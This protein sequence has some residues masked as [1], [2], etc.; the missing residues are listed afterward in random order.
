M[1]NADVN[2]GGVSAQNEQNIIAHGL[3]NTKEAREARYKEI[4]SG[5]TVAYTN[6]APEVKTEEETLP[7]TTKTTTKRIGGEV[8]DP[9]KQKL[10]ETI[11]IQN[12]QINSLEEQINSLTTQL[13]SINALTDENM[14]LKKDIISLKKEIADLKSIK[15]EAGPISTSTKLRPQ[16]KSS[17]RLAGTTIQKNEEV[18]VQKTAPKFFARIPTRTSSTPEK[19]TREDTQE[20]PNTSDHEIDLTHPRFDEAI[21]SSIKEDV[22]LPESPDEIIDEVIKTAEEEPFIEDTE[23][24]QPQQ[25][26]QESISD[27]KPISLDNTGKVIEITNARRLDKMGQTTVVVDGIAKWFSNNA[28][29]AAMFA[30]S[31]T[32]EIKKAA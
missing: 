9:A 30:N 8:K 29:N 12:D 11:E 1:A 32:G 16:K 10:I 24:A 25:Q 6:K 21:N 3:L 4:L 13:N 5:K 22:G 28:A 23:T 17:Y 18:K 19:V 7:E 15:N 31:A 26:P 20:N 2:S 27:E 14:S